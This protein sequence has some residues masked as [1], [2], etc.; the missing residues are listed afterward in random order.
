MLSCGQSEKERLNYQ[1]S[2]YKNLQ[3]GKFFTVTNPDHP[4]FGEW[5]FELQE[6]WAIDGAGDDLFSKIQG[7]CIDNNGII[8]VLDGK[9]FKVFTFDSE[10][11]FLFSFGSPGEGPGEFMQPRNLYYKEKNIIIEDINNRLAYYDQKGKFRKA[12]K[13]KLETRPRTFIDLIHYITIHTDIDMNKKSSLI[14]C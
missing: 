14:R 4:E 11:N 12:Y 2:I 8:Y 5:D 3:Q 13:F 9:H 10:G 6:V 7:I 1:R